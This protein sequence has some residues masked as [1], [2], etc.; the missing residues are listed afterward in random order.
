MPAARGIITHENDKDH[1]GGQLAD[2]VAGNARRNTRSK[3]GIIFTVTQHEMR[4][5]IGSPMM[6]SNMKPVARAISE[7]MD[8]PPGL[9]LFA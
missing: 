9:M 6:R 8:Y 1:A 7:Y 4:P 3:N 5:A 2:T